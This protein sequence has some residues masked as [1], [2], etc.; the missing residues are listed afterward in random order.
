MFPGPVRFRAPHAGFAFDAAYLALPLRR[1]ERALQA[2]L[3]RALPLTVLQYRRDRLLAQ[4]V[5]EALRADPAGLTDAEAIAAALAVSVRT[6]HR[7]LRDEGH[8]LQRLKDEVR[9]ER[10][11]ELLERS[12]RPIKQIAR[13]VGFRN[14]K[15]FARAFRAWTGATPGAWREAGRRP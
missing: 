4:R 15:S 7:Q 5:R 3:Q 10:A 8:A 13:A 1:D 2:M 14:E 6:L 12:T 9:R 11:L